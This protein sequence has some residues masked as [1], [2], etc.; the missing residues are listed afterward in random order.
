FTSEVGQ[1]GKGGFLSPVHETRFSMTGRLFRTLETVKFTLVMVLFL[2]IQYAR[3]E[4][5]HSSCQA[6]P[7]VLGAEAKVTCYFSED[8]RRR[9]I[10]FRIYRY[11]MTNGRVDPS[12]EVAVLDCYWETKET[13]VCPEIAPGYTFDHTVSDQLTV[14]MQQATEDFL[15]RYDCIVESLDRGII[16]GCIFRLKPGDAKTTFLPTGT[17]PDTTSTIGGDTH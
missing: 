17:V 13:F 10:N 15:G 9:N 3:G 11:N 5:I 12:S 1:K 14:T 2:S 8:L 4:E 16:D 7:V 6:L